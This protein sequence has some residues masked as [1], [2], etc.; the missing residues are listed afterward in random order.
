MPSSQEIR[1]Q[2]LDYFTEKHGHRFVPSS[3]VIPHA[4]PTL[5]FTN[6][7]MNQFKD[8][9]L[10][11]GTRDYTRAVNTQKCIRAGG[12]H[13][14]LE[15]VGRDTYHH[16]F[17]E[18]LGNW[19]F[20]DYF[21]EEAIAWAWELLTGVW[22]LKKECLHATVFGGDEGDGLAPDDEAASLWKSV[23]DID[24]THV[25]A[26]GKKDNFWEM[27]ETGPCGPCSEI[28]VDLTPDLSGAALVNAGDPRV[29]EIWNLV[30][31]QFNR[32]ADGKLTTLPARHVDT[33]M[34][35]ERVA[36]VL[37][38]KSS[39]YDTDVF[40]PLF[41]TIRDVTGV[42]PYGGQLDDRID[43]AYRV[44]AD[45][46]RCLTFA[47]T[48]GAA[49]GN[50]GRSYVLRRILRRAARHGR[51]T[52]GMEHPFLHR[53]VDVVVS[54]MG[55]VFPE[56]KK[57]P[58]QVAALIEDEER[59]FLKT[60]D[61][62]LQLFEEAATREKK[63]RRIAAADAFQLH[64]TFG[65]PLDLTQ[66]MAEERGLTVDTEGF[67][68][69][70]E[71]ARQ[72]SRGMASGLTGG[73][74]EGAPVNIPALLVEIVQQN[75]LSTTFT[76][77]TEEEGEGTM[78]GLF[79]LAEDKAEKVET[80]GPG[81]LLAVVTDSTP[82]YAEQGGQVG[83]TG[84]IES[85][86]AVF[87]VADTRRAGTTVFHL[88]TV[89]SG[90]LTAG[91][92]ARLAIDRT[93]RSRIRKNHTGTH[94]LNL[95]LRNL[96]NDKT[97][98]KGSL[99][100]DEKLRFDFSNPAALTEE[101]V[102]TIEK[103]VQEDIEKDLPVHAA[104]AA[105]EDARR[106]SGL[107]AVFGEKYPE[108][109]RV[110]SIGATLKD[111]LAAPDRG[112]WK[113]LSIE[114]CGGT[115]LASTGSVGSLVLVHEEAV[116]KGIRRVVAFTGDRADE[117]TREAAR[118][119]TKLDS[120]RTAE[121]DALA[122]EISALSREIQEIP[123]PIV[124]TSRLRQGL[125][126]LHETAKKEHKERTRSASS[127]VVE[128]ARALADEI[129]G[130]VLVA[131]LDDV[132]LELLRTA[133]DVIRQKKPGVALLLGSASGDKCSFV[134]CVPREL[135]D[136]GLKAGDWVR[137]VAKVTGGGGGGRPDMAQAGGK[138]PSKLHDALVRGRE[139]AAGKV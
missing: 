122:T 113:K 98:Q 91:G 12:K 50:E 137:E 40:S 139:F 52:L 82:F 61:R 116:A 132:D 126:E 21:K 18:M 47:L 96:V 43:V 37:Q 105:L 99:V 80:A 107:R 119:E 129:D 90:E 46:V 125:S 83:D 76:G 97:D 64:D 81:N 45:H 93:R 88:G 30:F 20:G 57:D 6:A 65:F 2:F 121:G 11:T 115:H 104:E 92:A 77:D 35:F 39:N 135:I 24:P 62:G 85:G 49:P 13:N 110:V 9:F 8:V 14:D 36:A 26:F 58:R 130:S 66:V 41:A 120:L 67:E 71:A 86:G 53:L 23:T 27:G 138:D 78:L 19:S 87:K 106:I 28:H 29:I 100:D 89:E 68:T 1:Q 75:D 101:Q 17:F 73:L 94:L 22:G 54:S 112:E 5:L 7:G 38:G 108:R 69:L 134:A 42:R 127:H 10:A 95:A 103:K 15:D 70:M 114:F 117:A 84:R 74:V 34:G 31:I 133:M 79:R 4:D 136:R 128:R 72:K 16:T 131:S 33:G 111:L 123:L 32:G 55:T 124:A 44:I 56:L 59:S 109:V 118:L 3:P 25:H 102:A 63:S 60:L 51:Q 48:D